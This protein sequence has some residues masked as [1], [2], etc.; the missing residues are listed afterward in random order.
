MLVMVL[1]DNGLWVVARVENGLCVYTAI[2][3]ERSTLAE[4]AYKP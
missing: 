2:V 3:M 4:S 1:M